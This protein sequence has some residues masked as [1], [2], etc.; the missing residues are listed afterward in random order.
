MGHGAK[1]R[2]WGIR[3]WGIHENKFF[4]RTANKAQLWRNKKHDFSV[5]PALRKILAAGVRVASR[6]GYV[7]IRVGKEKNGH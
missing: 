4:V 3:G 1:S 7:Q 6:G 5:N 2:D